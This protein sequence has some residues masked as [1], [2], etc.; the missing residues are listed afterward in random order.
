[1]S[2]NT[3]LNQKKKISSLFLANEDEKEID[4]A[5]GVILEE[6]KFYVN[7]L[8]KELTRRNFFFVHES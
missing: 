8:I 5:C 2:T 1:M 3:V 7:T 6:T 4:P